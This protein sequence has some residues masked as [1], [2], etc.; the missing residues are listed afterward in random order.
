[1]RSTYQPSQF[2]SQSFHV[3][4][5]PFG[6]PQVQNGERGKAIALG[7]AQAITAATSVGAWL[8]LMSEYGPN[9]TIPAED[10]LRVRR[11]Q[12]LEIG[13]GVAFFAL[14]AYGVIDGIRHYKPTV[15]VYPM[16]VSG[17]AGAGVSW[18]H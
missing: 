2:H 10:G 1:V 6:A 9:A 14:Y 15:T 18:S 13:T 7:T 16:A 17:G 8:Y 12:Q 3:N 5:I 4:F 11:L